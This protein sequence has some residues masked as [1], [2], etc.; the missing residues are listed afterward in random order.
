MISILSHKH[1]NLFYENNKTAMN[2]VIILSFIN[3][4]AEEIASLMKKSYSWEVLILADVN[5]N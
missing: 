3:S 2:H 1:I 5:V 4:I